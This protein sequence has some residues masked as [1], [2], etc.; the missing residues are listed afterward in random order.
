MRDG[1]FLCCSTYIKEGTQK[2]SSTGH[3]QRIWWW[4]LQETSEAFDDL[5]RDD[6]LEVSKISST[7]SLLTLGT[8]EIIFPEN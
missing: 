5:A 8:Q 6:L 1:A 2:P 3:T 7:Y 4:W